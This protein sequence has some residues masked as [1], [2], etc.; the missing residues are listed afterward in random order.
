MRSFMGINFIS[1]MDEQSIYSMKHCIIKTIGCTTPSISRNKNTYFF[2]GFLRF[3]QF[4]G[5]KCFSLIWI[6][7]HNNTILSCS[8]FL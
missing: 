6:Q 4:Q 7:T 3:F 1:I 5:N 8:T 2:I